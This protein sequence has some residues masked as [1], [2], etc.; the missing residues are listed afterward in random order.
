VRYWVGLGSNLGNREARVR[1]AIASLTA[2][3]AFTRLR[4]SSLYRSAPWGSVEQPAF[5][6]AVATFISA[7]EP[8][9]VLDVLQ[10]I[11]NSLGRR[12]TGPRWGPRVID[13]DLLLAGDRVLRLERLVVPHPRMHRRRFVLLPMAELDPDLI[14]PA[15]G[16]I[17]VLLSHCGDQE[18]RR[19]DQG[20]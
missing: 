6:N 18:V 14:I 11:E 5:I 13:L 1:Q 15:R 3:Q 2:Q 4:A 16:R 19:L 12:R 20:R 9:E 10:T 17:A 8:L 7:R